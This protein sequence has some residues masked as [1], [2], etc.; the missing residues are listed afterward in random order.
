MPKSSIELAREGV[1][2]AAARCVVLGEGES[3]RLAFLTGDD[4]DE[5]SGLLGAVTL[6]RSQ[7]AGF[8]GMV[9]AVLDSDDPN[10]SS[11]N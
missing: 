8:A 6:T 11:I 9:S 4:A 5:P 3:V 7:L 1:A 2:P 10:A